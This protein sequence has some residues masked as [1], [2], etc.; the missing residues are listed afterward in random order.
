MRD[1]LVGAVALVI[2]LVAGAAAVQPLV[3]RLMEARVEPAPCPEYPEL[4]ARE[5]S[6]LQLREESP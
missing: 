5:A 6:L 1:V 2:G 4:E 3:P